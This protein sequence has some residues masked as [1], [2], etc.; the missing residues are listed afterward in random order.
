MLGT[1]LVGFFAHRALPLLLGVMWKYR[2][3]VLLSEPGEPEQ[4][5]LPLNQPAFLRMLSRCL[6]L[7]TS[8][9]KNAV[10]STALVTRVSGK[11][12]LA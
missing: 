10:K 11:R 4:Y 12:P 9:F 7:V 5:L 2:R 8:A 6:S 1:A 3:A